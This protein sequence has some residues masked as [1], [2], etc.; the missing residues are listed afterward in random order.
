M[1]NEATPS[2]EFESEQLSLP[3]SI[4]LHLLPGA[5]TVLFFIFIA[6]PAASRLSLPPLFGFLLANAFVLVPSELGFLFYLGRKRHGRFFL[7]GV[8][9]YRQKLP[10]RDLFLIV[11]VLFV[12]AL[13]VIESLSFIDRFLFSR[14]FS[15][16][17]D[18]FLLHR[19]A[20]DY[21]VI[22]LL[23][24][25]GASLL[26]S[27]IVAPVTEEFYFHG[28]LLPRLSR[29]GKWAPVINTILFNFY[30][31]WSPWRLVSRTIFALPTA[32]AIQYKRSISIGIWWHCLGNIAGELIAL[33][34]VLKASS[35]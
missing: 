20:A 10:A 33:A 2:A 34:A 11:A 6:G 31:F 26:F 25:H 28:Y 8:V 17:P 23:T 3:R 14:F 7:E 1:N 5:F 29:F 24:I 30:H 16:L 4:V 13:I 18:W 32:Y 15:W 35:Y 27:G 12:W 9:L 21:P 19:T 22:L